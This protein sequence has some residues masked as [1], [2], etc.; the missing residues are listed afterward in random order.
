M[1][2]HERAALVA[3]EKADAEGMLLLKDPE[4][5]LAGLENVLQANNTVPGAGE[6]YSGLFFCW[7]GFGYAPGDDPEMQRIGRLREVLGASGA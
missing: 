1:A 2:G 6:A 4:Q 3:A 5:M 7:A